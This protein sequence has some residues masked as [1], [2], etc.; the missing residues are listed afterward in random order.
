MGLNRAVSAPGAG[1]PE[2]PD[3]AR[4]DPLEPSG[5]GEFSWAF[6]YTIL[7]DR[8]HGVIGGITDSPGPATEPGGG[9][10]PRRRLSRLQEAVRVGRRAGGEEVALSPV[11]RGLP[12]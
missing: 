7:A 5:R 9:Y 8:S 10:D 2:R 1:R 11:R 12:Y 6:G 3:R 4:S